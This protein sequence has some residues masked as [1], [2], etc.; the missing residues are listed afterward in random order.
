MTGL[1]NRRAFL[2]LV[3]REQ[4][5]AARYSQHTSFLVVDIDHFKRVNDVH[6][7]L[8]GDAILRGVA[9]AL[10]RATRT[11]DIVCRWGGEEFVIALPQTD[12]EGALSAAERVRAEIEATSHAL[13]AGS[14]LTVTA[15]IGAASAATTPWTLE[16]VLAKADAA[17]YEAKRA[18]RNRVCCEPVD[19]ASPEA[20]ETGFR[21]AC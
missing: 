18:G 1:T 15:S 5:R 3:G 9:R 7:H 6:G 10:G 21:Q 2:D 13:P 14:S 17:L 20:L 12:L 4:S 11:T 16:A 19:E 8:A